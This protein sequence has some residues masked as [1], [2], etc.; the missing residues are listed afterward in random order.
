M[1]E[2]R[3]RQALALALD[4]LEREDGVRI[5]HLSAQRLTEQLVLALTPQPLRAD[6]KSV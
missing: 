1:L 5:S 4:E 3:I 2:D 6:P